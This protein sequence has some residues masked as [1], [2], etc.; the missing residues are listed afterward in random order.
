M[1]CHKPSVRM[2]VRRH[3]SGQF[4]FPIIC[5]NCLHRPSACDFQSGSLGGPVTEASVCLP[6]E[7]IRKLMPFEEGNLFMPL[8]IQFLHYRSKY[9]ILKQTTAIRSK[10]TVCLCLSV[11]VCLFPFV[12][13]SVEGISIL[14]TIFNC[15][16]N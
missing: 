1:D 13:L 12:C 3:T 7:E 4:P 16:Y 11:S 8:Y 6:N 14:K 15:T 5:L 2:V 9:K 10:S